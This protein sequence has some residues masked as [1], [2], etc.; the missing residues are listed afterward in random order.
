[1]PISTVSPD[2]GEGADKGRAA[3]AGPHAESAAA[4]LARTTLSVC[5]LQAPGHLSPATRLFLLS[6]LE[7]K[8][9][10]AVARVMAVPAAIAGNGHGSW[11]EFAG[12]ACEVFGALADAYADLAG[13]V[14]A[15]ASPLADASARLAAVLAQRLKWELIACAAPHPQ[16]WRWLGS[17]FCA[18]GCDAQ[19]DEIVTR[20]YLRAIAY[21]SSTFDQVPLE[22]IS[23]ADHLIDQ[24]LPHL[25]LRPQP[26]AGALYVVVPEDGAPPRRFVVGADDGLCSA[27]YFHP[28]LATAMLRGFHS[29]LAQGVV[30]A[31]MGWG[32]RA[33]NL[34]L[35]EAAQHLLRQWSGSPPVRRHHRHA[36]N[37]PLSAVRGFPALRALFRGEEVG[38]V[39]E[40]R[41]CDASRGGV[42][43]ALPETASDNIHLGDL[44]GLR[45]DEGESW[46]LGIVRRKRYEEDAPRVGVETLAARPELISVDD[47]RTSAEVFLCD[48]LTK[49]EA[50]RVVVPPS[51]LRPGRPLFLSVAGLV[52]KLKPLDAYLGGRGF[53]LRVYQVV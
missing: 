38:A 22:S 34:H 36:L 4:I 47:G 13:F 46:H 30:P 3:G 40:W 51:Q 6:R 8:A 26:E 27:L 50:V 39:R 24:V 32:G 25:T 21:L 1:M 33:D 23:A 35:G 18:T 5:G 28:G 9:G 10:A 17:L 31:G 49:G 42:G 37:G 11:D 53:E 14:S 41:M 16:L 15:E 7:G 20:E 52:R 12:A 48:P 43:A 44:V 19:S 29:Q 45:A 2:T